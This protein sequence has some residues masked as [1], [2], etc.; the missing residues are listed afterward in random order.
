[1]DDALNLRKEQEQTGHRKEEEQVTYDETF[2]AREGLLHRVGSEDLT[3]HCRRFSQ[4][5]KH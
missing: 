2:E 3:L 1:M 5:T 4:E